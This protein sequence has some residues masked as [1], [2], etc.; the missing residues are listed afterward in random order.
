MTSVAVARA[1]IAGRLAAAGV[2]SGD[3]DARLLVAHVLGHPPAALTLVAGDELEG[4]TERRLEDLVARRVAREPLQLILGSVGFRYLELEVRS[5]VFVPRPET[6]VLA[7]EAIARTP[8]AGVVVEPCTGTGAVACAIAQEAAPARVVATD[9][10]PAALA[11]ARANVAR[12][13]LAVEVLEA[14]LLQ[15]LDPSLRGRID[16]LVCNPPYLAARELDGLEPE[17]H[18]DPVEALVAGPTGHEVTDRLLDDGQEW[19][20]PGGWLL[21]ETDDGRAGAT[22]ERARARCWIDVATSADL[23]GRDRVV[24]ARRPGHHYWTAP[25]TWLARLVQPAACEPGPSAPSSVRSSD[26]HSC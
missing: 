12:L 8:R 16:V 11:L 3:V 10:S 14:D 20:A 7:G 19:L 9:R 6:E 21:L 18:A 1:A 26:L 15:G 24:S 4:E 25:G 22:A 17:V 2:A 23:T 5:G 13:G